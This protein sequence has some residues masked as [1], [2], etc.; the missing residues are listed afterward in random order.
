MVQERYS[1]GH[2]LCCGKEKGQKRHQENTIMVQERN[3]I[4]H[5]LD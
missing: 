1:I 4:G 3:L 5:N 2:S